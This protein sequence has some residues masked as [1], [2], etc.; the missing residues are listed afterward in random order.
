[1]ESAL[2][3]GRVSQDGKGCG[4]EGALRTSGRWG[5]AQVVATGAKASGQELTPHVQGHPRA[6]VAKLSVDRD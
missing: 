5:G 2:R 6:Q 4:R 3:K 1:M